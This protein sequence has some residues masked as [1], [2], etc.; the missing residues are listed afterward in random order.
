VGDPKGYFLECARILRPGG[1]L[2]VTTHG[3]IQEHGCPYD[4]QRWTCR[5]LEEL[6]KESGFR[7]IDSGKTTTEVRAVI[8]LLH[9]LVLH[10]RSDGRPLIHYPLAVLRKLYGLLLLPVFNK[11]AD[12]FPQNSVEPSTSDASLYVGV[13]VRA[14][15]EQ[16]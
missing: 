11:F 5:G 14:K 2:L 12:L 16:A 8:Q 13:Y 10:L 15:K 4:F 1:Q 7:I 9:Q 6:V 3:M